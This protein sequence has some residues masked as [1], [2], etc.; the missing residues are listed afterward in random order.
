MNILQK[1]ILKLKREKNA[2][3]LAH[4]YQK[5]E[6]YKV[7]DFIGDS[8]EL[9][10]KTQ[11]IK[12][13]KIIVFCGVT[14]MAEMAKILNPN[15]KVLI[16]TLAAECPMAASITPQKL[17]ELKK[18]YPKAKVVSYVNTTAEIKAL[19]DSCCTSANA[20]KIITNLPGK[21]FIFVPDQNLADYVQ[22]RTSKKIISI[23][24]FCYVHSRVSKEKLLEAK[25][26]HPKAQILIHP[27]CP[28]EVQDLADEILSTSGMIKYV[29]K[30]SAEE[31][32]IG[33]EIGLLELLKQAA[34][35]KKF[36]GIASECIQQKKINLKNLY[37]A[38][39]YEQFEI[40]LDKNIMKK[41]KR[42]LDTML[43]IGK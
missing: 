35:K 8:F 29:K 21:E 27:E 26:K 9:A 30:S 24:G 34:P 12:N 18:K 40:L 25:K 2:V 17:I 13:A 32:I 16:P 41:A 1:K 43:K 23:K 36:Y 42:S 14:F 33:T 38:L 15:K 20:I 7:A 31:F 6:I 10:K 4:N 22:T 28:K 37:E 11:E 5:P 19:T 39:K 3:I